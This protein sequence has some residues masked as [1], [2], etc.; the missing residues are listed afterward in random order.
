MVGAAVGK[1]GMGGRD[2][3]HGGLDGRT[4][5]GDSPMPAVPITPVTACV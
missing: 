1:S 4:A 5:V 3:R 2:G